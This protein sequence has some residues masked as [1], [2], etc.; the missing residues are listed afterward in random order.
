M[1]GSIFK[2]EVIERYDD[3][4][5]YNARFGY[6]QSLEDV[7]KEIRLMAAHDSIGALFC[8]YVTEYPINEV[9]ETGF[10]LTKRLYDKH[11]K[12]LDS[13]LFSTTDGFR[14]RPKSRIRFKVG[15]K[16]Q[17]LSRGYDELTT[18]IV[19]QVPM[20]DKDYKEIVS[21]CDD[22]GH[23]IFAYDYTDDSYT[24]TFGFDKIKDIPPE[25]LYKHHDHID[26]LHLFP[27]RY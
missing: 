4:S 13:R 6:F 17:V 20:T 26:A 12:L 25:E 14:G 10:M 15:D 18:A 19:L 3:N 16:V 23:D 5:T 27:K 8:I 24:V 9:E 22:K 1:T 21:D 2:L 7:E 11:G